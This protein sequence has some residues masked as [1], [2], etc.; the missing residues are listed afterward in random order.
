MNRRIF[1]PLAVAVLTAVVAASAAGS[2]AN[3]PHLI[4]LKVGDA[5]DVLNTRVACFAIKSS[6][7]PGVACVLWSKKSK[8]LVGSYGIGLAVD[9]TAVLNRI[10]ADGSAQSIFKKRTLASV[11]KV[12]KVKVGEGFGLPAPNGTILGCQVL[13]ITSTSLAP[14][15]RGLKVSCWIATATEPL[16][17]R[18]G[19]SI[20]DKMAGVFKFTSTGEVSK[21]GIVRAQPRG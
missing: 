9:G 18:Y 2:G 15:Y 14:I 16:P 19:V 11:R 8:P 1:I 10:K 17:N 5:V 7:K 13:N 12:Y 20:S 3:N 6:G 21:W 4:Q